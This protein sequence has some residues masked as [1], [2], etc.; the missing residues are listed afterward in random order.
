[1][2][3]NSRK[4]DYMGKESNSERT[5]F[6]IGIVFV[7]IT[8]VA[9]ILLTVNFVKAIHRNTAV[10]V[11]GEIA[12][13]GE[14]TR[15][16]EQVL[17]YLPA[18][19]I[20]E[21]CEVVWDIDGEEVQRTIY[22]AD[23]EPTLLYTPQT[24]G[25]HVVTVKA[26]RQTQ[27][28]TLRVAL[29]HL[30]LTAPSIT[31]TYGEQI[32]AL[33]AA[34]EGYLDGEASAP[35]LCSVDASGTPSAGIYRIDVPECDCLGYETEY[36]SGTL[37]VLPRMLGVGDF[38]KVYDG[39]S[40]LAD[41]SIDL[42]GVLGSDEVRPECEVLYYDNKNVGEGKA[43]LLSTVTL[44]GADARNYT[45]PDYAEGRILPKEIVLCDLCVEDKVYDGTTRATVKRAGRLDGVCEGDSVAIGSAEIR[46]DGAE[47]GV[48]DVKAQISLVGADKGNYRV[49]TE[50]C[51][52]EITQPNGVWERLLGKEPIAQGSK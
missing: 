38:V 40:S 26:G 12:S 46:F 9:A 27:T 37:T 47:P 24:G 51:R 31:V 29:P 15:G 8:V 39:A 19:P 2:R 32:P 41:P 35:P 3:Q 18:A 17:T 1:M 42:Y 11:Q 48:H 7:I 44:T 33:Y 28:I 4:E 30:V 22:S 34:A 13:D 6:I 25:E 23:A 36:I 45:L 21:G 14:S 43:V 49:V 5:D 20:A 10:L 50:G 52:A 16:R